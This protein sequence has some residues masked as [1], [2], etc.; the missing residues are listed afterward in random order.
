MVAGVLWGLAACGGGR[1]MDTTIPLDEA[2]VLNSEMTSTFVRAETL[3]QDS[4]LLA[5]SLGELPAGIRASDFD[6]AMVRQVLQAC[7]TQTLALVPGGS[8]SE[9]PRA[10]VAAAGPSH[11]PLTQRPAVGR[12]QPCAPPR[13][14]VLENYLETA[15]PQVR[16][17]LQ[18][19]VLQVDGL[20]VNLNDTLVAQL[21]ALERRA[22]TARAEATRLRGMAEERRA[23]AQAGNLDELQRRQVEVDYDAVLVELDNVESV[24]QRVDSLLSGM[25]TTRRQLVD[26]AARNLTTLGQ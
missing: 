11:R 19:R 21:D 6:A 16:A 24:L 10:A 23:L 22:G 8:P 25:R 15:T 13:M 18:E 14:N 9:V 2:R 26:E 5:R 12:A 1:G 20:R 4:A 3:L 7:F 17:F